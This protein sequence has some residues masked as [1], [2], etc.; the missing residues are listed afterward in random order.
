MRAISAV[1]TALLVVASLAACDGGAQRNVDGND[2]PLAMTSQERAVHS[3][4]NGYDA[5]YEPALTTNELADQSSVVLSGVISAVQDGRPDGFDAD[6]SGVPRSIVVVVAL[7]HVTSGTLPAGSDGNVY[8]ELPSPYSTA[9]K[10]YSKAFPVGTPV[11]LYLDPAA[12]GSG[13]SRVLNWNAGRPAGQPLFR[14]VNPQGFLISLPGTHRFAWAL[15]PH[16][17]VKAALADVL[18]GGSTLLNPSG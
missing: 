6:Q 8:V 10:G 12:N 3:L 1:A 2:R 4:F 9:P 15:D 18:P 13:T 5:D 14:P 16:P 17:S 11:V 7:P